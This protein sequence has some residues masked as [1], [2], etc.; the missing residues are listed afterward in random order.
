M[1]AINWY[2]LRE[3]KY[4]GPRR[5][6]TDGFNLIYKSP[7]FICGLYWCLLC[8]IRWTFVSND[9]KEVGYR[10]KTMEGKLEQTVLRINISST[11]G[12][13]WNWTL[14]IPDTTYRSRLGFVYNLSWYLCMSTT[15]WSQRNPGATIL[16]SW[17]LR[18]IQT[19]VC[20]QFVLILVHE[21][22]VW[23]TRQYHHSNFDTLIWFSIVHYHTCNVDV[24]PHVADYI[25]GWNLLSHNCVFD[26]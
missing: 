10:V 8:F 24:K 4:G 19:W 6:S 22:K 15:C 25:T 5:Y 12:S 20:R 26:T 1:S 17:W 3:P 16:T 2:S 7:H 23:V 21:Y 13:V 14:V 9:V 18:E 11:K